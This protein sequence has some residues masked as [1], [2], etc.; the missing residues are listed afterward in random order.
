MTHSHRE[1]QLY[2]SWALLVDRIPLEAGRPSRRAMVLAAAA[3]VTTMTWP[4]WGR[5]EEPRLRDMEKEEAGSRH[6]LEAAEADSCSNQA[7][8]LDSRNRE[9]LDWP[10]RED[11]RRPKVR[12]ETRAGRSP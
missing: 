1:R 5:R 4:T 2:L 8:A 11:L 10:H 7:E 9:P 3:A 12:S 6:I